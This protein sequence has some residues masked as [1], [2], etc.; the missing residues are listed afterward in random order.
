MKCNVFHHYVSPPTLWHGT[1][2]IFSI[3]LGNFG[4]IFHLLTILAISSVLKGTLKVQFLF[5]QCSSK[6]TKHV[7]MIYTSKYFYNFAQHFAICHFFASW[8]FF[9]VLQSPF[10]SK[11]HELVITVLI[12]LT[13][14]KP[15]IL[16]NSYFLDHLKK[17]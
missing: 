9:T 15:Q 16:I 2:T 14:M 3:N 5:L 11:W 8:L 12:T 7:T 4:Q 17:I 6:H 1:F 10:T 13:L